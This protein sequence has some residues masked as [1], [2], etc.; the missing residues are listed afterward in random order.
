MRRAF[1]NVASVLFRH[2]QT[3]FAIVKNVS[4]FELLGGGSNIASGSLE[5]SGS[6]IY[7][8]TPSDYKRTSFGTQSDTSSYHSLISVDA[9]GYASSNVYFDGNSLTRGS[10]T[11]PDVPGSFNCFGFISGASPDFYVGEAGAYSRAL[12][13]TERTQLYSYLKAKWGTA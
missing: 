4:F 13:S 8:Y 12:N 10:S 6:T 1:C 7:L 9:G 11:V 3:Y 2:A 5:W